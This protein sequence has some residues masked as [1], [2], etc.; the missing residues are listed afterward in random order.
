MGFHDEHA[1]KFCLKLSAGSEQFRLASTCTDLAL[2]TKLWVKASTW[3]DLA[4]F[5]KL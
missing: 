1:I 3:A 2:F 4:L 5:T